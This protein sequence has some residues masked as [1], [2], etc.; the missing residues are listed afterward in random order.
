[1]LDYSVIKIADNAATLFENN[2]VRAPG[3]DPVPITGTADPVVGAPVCKSGQK[4]GYNCGTI[5]WINQWQKIGSVA[6]VNNAFITNVCVISGDSGGPVLTGTKAL[7]ITNGGSGCSGTGNRHISSPIN[8]ILA[9]NPG[10]K[11]RTN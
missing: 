3:S 1:G 5:K 2:F 8:S 11:I 10:L 7:G 4:T 9:D 6:T